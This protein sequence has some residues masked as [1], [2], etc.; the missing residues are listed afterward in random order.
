MKSDEAFPTAPTPFAPQQNGVPSAAM[1]HATALSGRNSPPMLTAEKVTPGG[2]AIGW[3][4]VRMLPWS[5]P[6]QYAAPLLSTPQDEFSAMLTALKATPGAFTSVGTG[7]FVLVPLPSSPDRF[8]PQ[9]YAEPPAV[10][11]Q[12]WAGPTLPALAVALACPASCPPRA[13][14]TWRR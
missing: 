1:P 13:T 3:G 2:A 11:P 14:R 5:T 8:Q 10:T 9:Q 4:V 7:L 6:Q 12:A